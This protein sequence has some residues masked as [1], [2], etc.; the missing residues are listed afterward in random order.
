MD[1]C[2]EM[3]GVCPNVLHL[4][5]VNPMAMNCWALDQATK[6]RTIRLCH[7]VPHTA[8]ELAHDIGVPVE[9]INYV[10]AGINHV[11]F[12]LRFERN[13]HDLYPEIRRVVNEGRLKQIK[14]DFKRFDYFVTE[15]SEHFSE[16]GPWLIKRFNIPLDEYPRRCEE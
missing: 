11:A 14:F 5:Y 4:N 15:S 9:E 2:R 6:V 3:E 16:Y 12:Y 1:M 7:S 8:A 13:G 10:V